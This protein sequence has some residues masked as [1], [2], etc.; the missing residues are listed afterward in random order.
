[1]VDMGST[2]PIAMPLRRDVEVA[3]YLVNIHGPINPASLPV[4]VSPR[5]RRRLP[6]LALP[7]LLQHVKNMVIPPLRPGQPVR[8]GV[9]ESCRLFA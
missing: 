6:K 8:T 1:M 4:A 7:R 9:V 3:L 5:R 2:L